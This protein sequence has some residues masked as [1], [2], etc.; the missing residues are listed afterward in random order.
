[1]G[2]W[3]GL[4]NRTHP[5]KQISSIDLELSQLLEKLERD[6]LRRRLK[7][8]L[9]KQSEERTDTGENFV[10]FGS[11]D[12]LG[13]ATEPFLAEAA[14][15]AI[16]EHGTGSGASRLISGNHAPH[17]EL[18]TALATWKGTEAALA[19]SSGH[20]TAVGVIPA[21]IGPQ[22]VVI[23]DKLSH[24]CIID[25]ARLSGAK[26]RVFPHNSTE[27]L[28]HH[29][30][31]ARSKHPKSRVLIATESI[32]SMDGDC[33]P[34]A[35]IVELKDRYDAWVL[36][37]EA[38]AVGVFG[39]TGGGLLQE[40]GLGGRVEIQM[41]TLSKGLGCS[42][43]YI[44]GSRILI[45]WLINKARSLIYSTAPPPGNARAAAVAVHWMAS[46]AAAQRRAA[47]W[48]NVELIKRELMGIATPQSPIVPVIVGSN[49]RAIQLSN[50][51]L[52][53]RFL[54]PAI[55]YPTVPRD[56]ARLRITLSARHTPEAIQ[57]LSK[58]I[59]DHLSDTA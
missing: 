36:V 51:L 57:D 29:L 40:L 21:L 27:K 59:R 26:I 12:Y 56:R 55:R 39:P 46:D 41:G 22:D 4:Q 33:A 30:Q 53:K 19:F 44:C 5:L 31:W 9:P 48:K 54:A 24:A 11:N 38:H 18:E 23:L 34:L 35:E 7:T 16:R 1:V 58:A 52:S 42:G 8:H 47:L 2:S 10:N 28:E 50:T 32:F 49:T 25:G 15:E 17:D 3:N 14:I 37:D 43:G 20:A 45:D 13:L 6:S